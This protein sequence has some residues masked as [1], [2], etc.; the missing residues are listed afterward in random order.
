MDP[1]WI[2]QADRGQI[3]LQVLGRQLG[4][5]VVEP[6]L[7]VGETCR[8]QP[9][10]RGLCGRE[11]LAPRKSSPSSRS[12]VSIDEMLPAPPHCAASWPPGLSTRARC[13]KS[14][15]WSAIQ[16]NVAVDRMASTGS[17]IASGCVRSPIR[18]RTR[19]PNGANRSRAA[20]IMAGEP[21]SAI[22]RPPA[23]VR[24]SAR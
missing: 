11:V 4:G 16:W 3:G 24:A 23:A 8:L 15:S 12:A 13:R 17:A 19:S 20:S 14:A 10:A 7:D 18:N 1:M 22:T 9:R 2:A 5:F 6:R 21:S